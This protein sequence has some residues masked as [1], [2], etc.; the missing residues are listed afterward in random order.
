MVSDMLVSNIMANASV[1]TLSTDRRQHQS[2]TAH[3][4]AVVT[5]R[6]F[7][8]DLTLFRYI[9]I[10]LFRQR[11]MPLLLITYRPDAML[12]APLAVALSSNK[13]SAPRT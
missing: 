8:V 1:E 6:R 13:V 10:L 9:W 2:Q 12:K 5:T 3:T 11:T 7:V 4:P